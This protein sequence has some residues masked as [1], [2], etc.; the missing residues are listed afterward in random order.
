LEKWCVIFR[1][2]SS[3]CIW[4]SCIALAYLILVMHELWLARNNLW[5]LIVRCAWE[6]E[7]V[8]FYV[9]VYVCDFKLLSFDVF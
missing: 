4:N 5:D 3:I 7:L 8:D 1:G 9:M 2:S 6:L